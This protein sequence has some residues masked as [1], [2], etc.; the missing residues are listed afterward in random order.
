MKCGSLTCSMFQAM[1]DRKTQED[2]CTLVPKFPDA[3][4]YQA[5]AGKYGQAFFGVFDGTVGDFASENVRCLAVQTL[6]GLQKWNEVRSKKDLQARELETITT[7]LYKTI[8]AEVLNRCAE[9]G[10]QNYT[11][12]TGVTIM[13]LGDLLVVGHVGDSRVILGIQKPD[14]M[15]GEQLTMDHK[16][17]LEVEKTRIEE[18][19]GMVE[20]LQN[21]NNKA[22]LRGGDFLMRKAL[23]ETPM[24]LQYSRA[25]GA[26]D[27]KPF[28]LVCQPSVKVIRLDGAHKVVILAS[29]GLW[30]VISSTDAAA[31]AM[32]EA[33]IP[34]GGPAEGY[35][36][37]AERLV[38]YAL[39]EN[40]KKGTRA[41]NITCVCVHLY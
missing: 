34:P 30:D 29:D 40:R 6:S 9:Q 33:F 22:F 36:N 35:R 16:P 31:I 39:S 2:R 3:G 24:Q 4:K 32:E 13:L 7:E 1:G 17:E 11:T 38:M 26:K 23:G 15:L 27:L 8:D 14:G 19:G 12:C 41:D 37:P 18:N 10:N 21:H 25:F 5:Q 20:R 28:G